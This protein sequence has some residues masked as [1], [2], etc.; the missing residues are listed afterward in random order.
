MPLRPSALNY[1][2]DDGPLSLV[3]VE[4]QLARFVPKTLSV[5]SGLDVL[6]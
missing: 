3:D 6:T 5:H 1:S 2:S 4:G